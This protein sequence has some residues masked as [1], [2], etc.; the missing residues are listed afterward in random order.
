MRRGPRADRRT[1]PATHM[2][3]RRRIARV[4]RLDGGT[5]RTRLVCAPHPVD[6]S[7]RMN[8]V[9]G[10]TTWGV[11]VALVCLFVCEFSFASGFLLTPFS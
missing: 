3:C 8:G 7:V 6:A 2:A 5:V 11:G 9:S 4:G 10:A 1:A